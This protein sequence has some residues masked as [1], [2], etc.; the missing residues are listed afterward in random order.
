MENLTRMGHG[1]GRGLITYAE[2]FP[3]DLDVWKTFSGRPAGPARDLLLM[4]NAF[5]GLGL[6]G[7]FFWPCRRAGPGL[8]TYAKSSFGDI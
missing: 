2:Y 3:G 7:N 4:L 1:S 5:R 8:I 6:M